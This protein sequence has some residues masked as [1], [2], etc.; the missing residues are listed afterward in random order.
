VPEPDNLAKLSAALEQYQTLAAD[1]QKTLPPGETRDRLQALFGQIKEGFA[2]LVPALAAQKE[3]VKAAQE[4]A[5]RLT[6]EAQAKLEAGKAKR[7]ALLARARAP[8]EKPV[9]PLDPALGDG[10][11]AL[12]R[13]EF[14]S[15]EG[16]KR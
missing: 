14:G 1:L 12:L 5:R 10:L 8:K 3:Q 11:R 15:E 7:E 9:Q 16:G 4:E 13:R 2:Q 6:A